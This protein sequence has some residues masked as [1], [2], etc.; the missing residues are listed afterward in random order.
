[1]KIALFL[2]QMD[3]RKR[4]DLKVILVEKVPP[5]YSAIRLPSSRRSVAQYFY[6]KVIK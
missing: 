1:M 2:I 4:V 5:Q 6:F 3:F